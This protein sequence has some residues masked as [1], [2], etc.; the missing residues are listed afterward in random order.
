MTCNDCLHAQQH[1]YT[2]IRF[3]ILL[4]EHFHY[5]H[6]EMTI[7]VAIMRQ[8]SPQNTREHVTKVENRT[9]KPKFS[10]YLIWKYCGHIHKYYVHRRVCGNIHNRAEVTTFK[11]QEGHPCQRPRHSTSFSYTELHVC[12]CP[13]IVQT[14]ISVIS[15]SAVLY[16]IIICFSSSNYYLFQQ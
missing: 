7:L 8:S 4:G 9:M 6:I 1:N 3:C 13:C 12:S 5:R 16:I 11:S 10:H 14:I 15:V 2:Y